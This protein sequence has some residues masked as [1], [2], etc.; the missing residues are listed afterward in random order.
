M[1][2]KRNEGTRDIVETILRKRIL[3]N[4]SRTVYDVQIIKTLHVK[5][6]ERAHTYLRQR[7]FILSTP[8]VQTN[9]VTVVR[10][11]DTNSYATM[12]CNVTRTSPR[13]CRCYYL[14]FRTRNRVLDSGCI[15]VHIHSLTARRTK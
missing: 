3:S 15:T 9:A 1:F 4:I 5:T 14:S 12:S 10:H 2:F 8:I 11:S 13:Y 6:L 7:S